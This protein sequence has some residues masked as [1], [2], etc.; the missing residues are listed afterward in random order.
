MEPVQL[1]I[2]DAMPSNGNPLSAAAAKV[3]KRSRASDCR[4]IIAFIESRGSMGATCDEIEVALG[5]KHQTA[6][7][8]VYDLRN[9]ERICNSGKTRATR[10][11]CQATVYWLVKG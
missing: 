4:D 5:L 3:A 1:T 7:A 9:A 8:R 10:S 6:S 2:L 11:G